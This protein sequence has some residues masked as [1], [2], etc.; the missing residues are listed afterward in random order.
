MAYTEY[1]NVEEKIFLQSKGWM[2]WSG[3]GHMGWWQCDIDGRN[4]YKTIK[5]VVRIGPMGSNHGSLARACARGAGSP[6]T[7]QSLLLAL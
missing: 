4:K 1:V 5:T 2:F 7:A 6:R 3:L